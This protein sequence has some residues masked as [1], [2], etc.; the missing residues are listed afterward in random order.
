MSAGLARKLFDTPH[1]AFGVSF[2]FVAIVAKDLQ[3]GGVVCT[4][5][6]CVNDVV[7]LQ[8]TTDT[9]TASAGVI[10]TSQNLITKSP[11]RTAATTFTPVTLWSVGLGGF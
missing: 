1:R 10:I 5:D 11:P 2:L 7:K 9:P 8:T 3:V 6:G 4:A